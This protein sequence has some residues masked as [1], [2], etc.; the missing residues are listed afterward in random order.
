MTLINDLLDGVVVETNTKSLTGPLFYSDKMHD[1]FQS[2]TVQHHLLDYLATVPI[3]GVVAGVIR[4]VL[5][6]FHIIAHTVLAICT[7]DKG[8]GYHVAKGAC[9][10]L[11]GLIQSIPI[12]G[13]KFTRWY[14]QHG[15]WWIIKIY[16]PDAPDSLDE[17]SNKWNSIKENRPTAYIIA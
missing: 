8:H 6:L 13:H 2:F 16:N 11:R 9:E 17:Y 1:E 10:F 5:S 3:L 14:N 15:E 12:V 7:R 4:V